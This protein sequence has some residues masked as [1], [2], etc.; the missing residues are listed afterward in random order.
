MLMPLDL[1]R[2]SLDSIFSFNSFFSVMMIQ[3]VKILFCLNWIMTAF[4]AY[5][6]DNVLPLLLTFALKDTLLQCT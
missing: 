2:D 3:N 4:W 1:L 5:A 6:R